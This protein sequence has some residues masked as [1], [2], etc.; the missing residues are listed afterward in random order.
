MRHAGVAAVDAS[1]A[2]RAHD[3]AAPAVLVCEERFAAVRWISVALSRPVLSVDTCAGLA[4]ALCAEERDADAGLT[5]VFPTRATVLLVRGDV[6]FAPV[7]RV[8]I[9][10]AHARWADQHLAARA[11]VAGHGTTR[12]GLAGVSTRAAVVGVGHSIDTRFIAKRLGADRSKH[13]NSGRIVIES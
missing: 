4:D 3:A 13:L 2:R 1:F 8:T 6:G 12:V 10:V 7:G 11:V 9:A 5:T